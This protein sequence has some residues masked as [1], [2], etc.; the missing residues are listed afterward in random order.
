MACSGKVSSRRPA[1]RGLFLVGGREVS[2][3]FGVE[4]PSL[5]ESSRAVDESESLSELCRATGGGRSIDVSGC[6]ERCR[7][8]L[9][10]DRIRYRWPEA[11]ILY[12]SEDC[13]LE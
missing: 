4:K 11:V 8:E 1:K 2:R 9:R 13:Q 12:Y 7:G 5:P 6:V 10:G 3:E